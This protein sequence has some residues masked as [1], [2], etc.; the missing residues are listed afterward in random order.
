[1]ATHNSRLN[2][3]MHEKLMYGENATKN[4]CGV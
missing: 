4:A 1:M 3:F 2:W